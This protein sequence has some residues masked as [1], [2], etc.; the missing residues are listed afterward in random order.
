MLAR[1]AD[2]ELIATLLRKV[3]PPGPLFD[4]HADEAGLELND[5]PRLAQLPSACYQKASP[6]L[7]ETQLGRGR[8]ATRLSRN[9][10]TPPMLRARLDQVAQQRSPDRG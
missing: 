4:P 7:G 10:R 6:G 9:T 3:A 1:P 8:A 5:F 2:P